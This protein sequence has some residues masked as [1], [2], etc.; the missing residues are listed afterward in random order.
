MDNSTCTYKNRCKNWRVCEYCAKVRQKKIAD[1]ADALFDKSAPLYFSV[2]RPSRSTEREIKRIRASFIRYS[3]TEKGLW[4]VE[5]G[6]KFAGLHLNVISQGGRMPHIR[7]CETYSELISTSARAV[8]AYITK[9]TGIP[10]EDFYTGR[11]FGTFGRLNES[12]SH[13]VMPACVQAAS[14]EALLNP[15]ADQ[16]NAIIKTPPYCPGWEPV[17][18]SK[19]EYYE[20]AKAHLPELLK[21]VNR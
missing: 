6:E 3:L 4:S 20:I 12:F 19:A 15:D 16:A 17:Y 18:K 11:I 14:I 5:T 2:L 21:A 9:S 10:A 8:A 7:D 13:R 1:L